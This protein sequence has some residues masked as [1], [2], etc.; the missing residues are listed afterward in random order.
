VS[1]LAIATIATDAPMGAQVYE[2]EVARGAA[3][4]LAGTG[5]DWSIR[6]V[7]ARSLR[8]PL[9]GTLRLPLGVLERGSTALRATAGRVVYPRGAVVHRMSLSLPP[10]PRDVVTLHDVVAWRF[11]DEG[12]PIAAA[13]EELRRAR[14]V[15]C[16]SEH[17]AA[18]AIE[19]FGIT[20]PRVIH[21]GVD[22]RFRHAVPLSAGKRDALGIRGRY[23]L[24]AGGASQRKNLEAL[25][26]AWERA[27]PALPDVTLVL[28]GPPHPRR[29][30]LFASLPRTVLL[31]RVDREVVPGLIAGA[32]AVV[33]PSLYEGFGLP[34]LEAM[35]AGTPVIAADASSLPE[36]AAG[37]ALL[38]EPFAGPIGDG[39]V[40]MFD[41][42]IDR[43][44]LIARGRERAAHFTWERCLAEHAQIWNDVAG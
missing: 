13:P 35:A 30:A 26:A 21:P 3:K 34:V 11:P 16:V 39:I 33:V 4:A 41:G 27:A 31:G 42:S 9:P 8:S 44:G 1:R 17:T 28:S 6:P 43:G 14:A 22:D 10:A 38:V 19:M 29:T 24:H 40:A 5:R 36:V 2:S 20:A 15:V 37:A 25:A 7:V 18:D 12:T 23:L 32:E